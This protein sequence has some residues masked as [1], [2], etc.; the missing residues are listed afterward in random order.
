MAI[1][2]FNRDEESLEAREIIADFANEGE[3]RDEWNGTLGSL[4]LGLGRKRQQY[5]DLV[6]QHNPDNSAVPVLRA[7]KLLTIGGVLDLTGSRVR[8]VCDQILHRPALAVLGEAWDNALEELKRLEF[9][10]I[11]PTDDGDMRL[12]ILKDDYFKYVVDDYPEDYQLQQHRAGLLNVLV[13]LK[14]DDA[15]FDLGNGFYFDDQFTSAI[16]AYDEAIRLNPTY[17]SAYYNKGTT[18][19]KLERYPEA[20][21]AYDEAIRLNPADATAYYNKGTTLGKL[22][23]YAEALAAYDEAIRLNPT[24]ASAYNNKSVALHSLGNWI[25][26]VISKRRSNSPTR[27]QRLA[28]ES[29]YSSRAWARDEA[30]AAEEHAKQLAGRLNCDAMWRKAAFRD[31]SPG[32]QAAIRQDNIFVSPYDSQKQSPIS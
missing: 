28:S 14:D 26:L 12:A 18:L 15:L 23:R 16:A 24:Y 3:I 8:A 5:R 19:G 13:S 27:C 32:L 29:R 20:L 21:A 2:T 31:G 9:V 11:T 17:A 4:V 30:Q 1:P 6:N 10:A 25:S 22:E 7:M